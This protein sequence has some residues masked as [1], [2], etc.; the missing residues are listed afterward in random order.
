MTAN[1]HATN[2]ERHSF[3]EREFD[4]YETP[5]VAVHALLHAEQVP[6]RGYGSRRAARA[7]S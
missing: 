4:L 6:L 5:A 1:R 7:Q 2:S 3:A